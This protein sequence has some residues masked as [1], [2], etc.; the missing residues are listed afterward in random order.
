MARA[1]P[2][3][4]QTHTKSKIDQHGRQQLHRVIGTPDKYTLNKLLG[5]E[6]ELV[7][8]QGSTRGGSGQPQQAPVHSLP[9]AAEPIV[10]KG[11]G[12]SSGNSPWAVYLVRNCRPKE[13]ED[14]HTC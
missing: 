9:R 11:V 3:T 14:H 13:A 5:F 1:R 6:L 4:L 10:C 12:T 8:L 7:G 2:F